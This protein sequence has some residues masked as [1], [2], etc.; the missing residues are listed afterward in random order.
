MATNEQQARAL[1]KEINEL[2]P[3]K[4]QLEEEI[5]N[6]ID[7]VENLEEKIKEDDIYFDGV[8]QTLAQIQEDID[9]VTKDH[10]AKIDKLNDQIE[11]LLTEV[12]DNIK[13]DFINS[14]SI[15]RFKEPVVII[16]AQSCAKC[17]MQMSGLEADNIMKRGDYLVCKGCSR[18]IVSPGHFS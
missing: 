6:L 1:E 10:T 16:K 15:N 7:E 5:L 11:G 9:S 2:S 14:R 18:V 13:R 17:R 12:P 3:K 4:D 8:N